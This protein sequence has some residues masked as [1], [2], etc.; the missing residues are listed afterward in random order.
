MT[1]SPDN[2]VAIGIDIGG[3]YIKYALIS[4]NGEIIFN[5]EVPTEATNKQQ[6]L[7]NIYLCIDT[8]TTE[9]HKQHFQVACI[10]IGSPG[11]VDQSAGVLV[12]CSNN[13][14][15]WSNVP[16]K[17]LVEDYAGVAVYLDNDANLIGVG[18][19]IYG[20]AKDAE[21]T[22]FV[23]L[24]TGIGGAILQNG[25]LYRGRAN[26]GSEFGCMMMPQ[27]N[28][29]VVMW[30]ALASAKAMVARYQQ[31]DGNT[32]PIYNGKVMFEQY[33]QGCAIAKQAIDENCFLVGL[34]IA[35]LINIFNPDKLVIGGGVSEAGQ[36]YIDNIATQ[37]KIYA[38]PE[39]IEGVTICA[40]EL[41]N[42]AGF[43]GAAFQAFQQI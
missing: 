19:A 41:G 37:A 21:Y 27:A 23:T 38:Q 24:G 6:V 31:L 26:A 13:I 15:G 10:G 12:G 30:E 39:C 8:A 2:R 33:H 28:G 35:N 34:G 25:Q 32:K 1:N 29:E 42:K 14:D 11:V 22:I 9:A 43:L 36:F 20:A 16:L 40:A 17:A 3:T 18:E 4:A 5:D 7:D